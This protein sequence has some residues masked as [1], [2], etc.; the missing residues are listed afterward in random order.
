MTR[1]HWFLITLALQFEV[2][3]EGKNFPEL[4]LMLY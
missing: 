4:F 1:I 2:N 3:I